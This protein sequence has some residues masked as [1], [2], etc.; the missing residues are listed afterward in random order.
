MLLRG[1]NFACSLIVLALIGT[2]FSIF[3]ATKS[4]TERNNLTPWAPKTNPWPQIL[5]LVISCISLA[6]CIGVFY[7]YYK[8]GHRQAEKVSVYYTLFS[9]LFFIFSVIMWVVAAAVL[10]NSK[11]SGNNKDLWGW[12]CVDNTRRTLFEQDVPYALV[13]RMQVWKYTSLSLWA[14]KIHE[15]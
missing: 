2:S 9:V 14:E 7:A 10:Q 5:V 11:D 8:G 4:L 3:N 13:C 6:F 1:V 12:A 15:K